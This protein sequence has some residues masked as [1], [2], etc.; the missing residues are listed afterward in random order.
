MAAQ[1]ARV[2]AENGSD[3]DRALSLVKMAGAI[4]ELRDKV[5]LLEAVLENFPGG[6]SLFDDNLQ[7]LLCNERQK[8][9]LE[10]PDELMANGYPS[11]ADLFR[12]NAM[13]GEYGPGDIEMHVRRRMELARKMEAHC[14]D[15]TRPNGTILEVRGMPLAGGGFVTTYLDVTEQRRTQQLVQHMAHHDPL[16]DL[17]NRILFN[18]RLKNAVAHAK[19]GGLMAVHYLDLDRFK[20]INDNH[21]HQA[22]DELLIGVAKRMLDTIRENDTVARLG[23][24]EFAIVQTGIH[25]RDDAVVLAKRILANFTSPFDL[26]CSCVQVGVSIGIAIAPE[27]GAT[28]DELLVKADNALYRSKSGGRNRF[29]F[30][31][32]GC[33]KVRAP[34]QRRA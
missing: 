3:A 34:A 15:R 31:E 10:Y 19:R 1:A 28:S 21:G 2:V 7:M 30:Y 33:E 25:R 4:N 29:S 18:D 6:I 16:T 22:G 27:D 23:G 32:A 26:A 9:L 13:R 14:Y 5:R 11:M 8:E 20:P 12:F 24:D 17:P